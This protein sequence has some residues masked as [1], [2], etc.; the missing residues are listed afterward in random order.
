M[1]HP[2]DVGA[3]RVGHPAQSLVT[4]LVYNVS[5]RWESMTVEQWNLVLNTVIGVLVI[6]YGIWLKN[7]V[8]QQVKAK[9]A[10]IQM[11]DERISQLQGDSA[12]AIATA[13]AT[14]RQHADKMTEDS[15][16]LLEQLNTSEKRHGSERLFGEVTGLITA[17]TLLNS[18]I[19]PLTSDP[20]VPPD[21]GALLKAVNTAVLKLTEQLNARGAEF[22]KF[23]KAAP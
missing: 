3:E 21:A 14:M 2:M 6:G 19:A 17:S 10:I 7:I 13:Y 4:V 11:K 1:G 22:R 23:T 9:E 15:T 5:P 16:R 12:P 20:A 8:D 18:L